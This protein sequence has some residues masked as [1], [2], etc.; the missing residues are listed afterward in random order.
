MRDSLVFYRSFYEALNCLPDEEYLKAIKMVL[1]YALND[2]EPTV[3]TG[4][5]YAVFLLI[6]PQI[7]AN[8]R[9]YINGCKGAEYG[10]LGGRPKTPRKPL[11]NPKQTP[12]END[13]ENENDNVNVNE[14]DNGVI[15]E[16][17]ETLPWLKVTPSK[18]DISALT[19]EIMFKNKI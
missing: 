5:A 4:M 19:K 17:E 11:E 15:G 3:N 16:E 8:N 14:N 18:R 1:D 9:R 12:N 13:N 7:D 6:K 10:K 2:I